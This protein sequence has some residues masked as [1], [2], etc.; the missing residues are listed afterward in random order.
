MII[1]RRPDQASWAAHVGGPKRMADTAAT[2]PVIADAARALAAPVMPVE[3]RFTGG[4]R[5]VFVACRNEDNADAV[6]DGR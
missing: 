2:A 5:P 3:Q 6:A 4:F 1:E